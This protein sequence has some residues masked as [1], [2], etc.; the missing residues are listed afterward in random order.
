MQGKR[1]QRKSGSSNSINLSTLMSKFADPVL[2]EQLVKGGK[3]WRRP[4]NS[5]CKESLARSTGHEN[6]PRQQPDDANVS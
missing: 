1:Y 6:R 2:D 5:R 3:L 4:G